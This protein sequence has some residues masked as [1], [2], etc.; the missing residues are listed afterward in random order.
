[1]A[2]PVSPSRGFVLL[3]LTMLFGLSAM[4]Q[5]NNSPQDLAD[6]FELP[7]GFHIYRAA[8]PELSGGSYALTFDGEGRLLVGDGNAVR[9]LIDKDGDGVFDSHEVIATG[10]GWR[11]PQGLLVYGDKLYAVGG[12]GIQ[13]FE[14]YRSGKELVHTGRI[15]NKLNT[16]GDHDAHTIFRGHDGYVYFMAGNGSG[17]EDRRHITDE[18]SPVM[19]EREASVF[20]ISPDGTKWECIGSGGRNPPNLGMNYL[21]ELFS[22]DSDM[23]W[24]V[25]LPW[26]RPVR[27]NHW[28]TG[29]DQGWQDVGAY[30]PYYIDCLP[31]ILD[32]GRGSPNWGV[33][34]EHNQFPEKYRDAYLVCDY[35]WKRESDDQ[36]A[37]T[38]RLVV[39]FLKREGAG[40]KASMETLARPKPSARDAEG[41]PINFA[42]VDAEVAP[43]GSLF[44]T[45]HNQGIWRIY[46]R[47][48]DILSAGGVGE[49]P[50][51]RSAPQVM[52]VPAEGKD[53]LDTLL[54]LPQPASE[55]SRLREVA[56]RGA[57]GKDAETLLQKTALNRKQPLQKRL[58]AIRL[59]APEFINLHDTFLQRLAM[60]ISPEIRGQAAWLMGIRHAVGRDSVEPSN[61]E[62]ARADSRPTN[63]SKGGGRNQE[64]FH[65]LVRL[66][67]DKDAFVRRR[68]AEALTR[69]HSPSAI[70]ALIERLGD[71]ERL[72]RYVAMTA[73]AHY[74]THDWFEA[75][76]AKS[77]PQIRMRALVVSLI[78]R[79]PPSDDEVRRVAKSF[80]AGAS[81]VTKSAAASESE[82]GQ[83]ARDFLGRSGVVNA[84]TSRPR[85]LSREDCLDLMR[86]LALFKKQI[87]ADTELKRQVVGHLL[88]GFPDSDR[89]IRFEQVRLLG[90]YRVSE[91]FSKLLTLLVADRDEVTQF[92]IAQGICKLES[93]W[94]AVE[95]ER[96]LHWMH[97]TQ[98]GW[99]AQFNGKGVEFPLFWST[100]LADFA[101]NHRDALLRDL[102][103]VNFASLLGG[104]AID[105][106]AESPNASE[107]L[108]SLYR[109]NESA[110]GRV[111]IVSA[112]KRKPGAAVGVFLREEFAKQTEPRLRGVILQSL[113]VQPGD[114]ANLPLFR[115]GLRHPDVDVVVACAGGIV[116][117]KPDLDENLANLL[118]SRMAERRSLFYAIDRTL[119]ALSNQTRPDH[120]PEPQPGERLEESTRSAAIEFWKDW[121]E[122]RFGKK[123]EATLAAGGRGRSDEELH[124]IILGV[125]LHVGDTT[126]GAKVYERLQCNSC[127]GGGV[128]PGQEGRLFGP[129][130]AGVT[131]RLSRPDLADAI[132]Y[133]S[134]QVVDRFK[135]QEIQLKEGEPLAGFIT[136]QTDD[137]VTLAARDQV[138]RIPRSRIRSIEPQATSLMPERAVNSLTDEEIRDLLA[139]LDHGIGAAGATAK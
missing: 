47:A 100:V 77:N 7:P 120:K 39:F 30:P 3:A 136:E 88:Q 90:E 130:L 135:A 64:A 127:H 132:V 80:L 16:G 17:I 128:T 45:D 61:Q 129:D 72:V 19:F 58:R 97:G 83:P 27:L 126:R 46:Y 53:A 20:R 26:W 96:L 81:S 86:T 71:S 24:H 75:A 105:L 138:H 95:E 91:A 139:F 25:G 49:T 85:S 28:A 52:L 82:R 4:A 133:P 57:L 1:M 21:G 111:K 113:A 69:F 115:E 65:V 131:R 89:D 54:S 112:L 18:S 78:R 119:V 22:F 13:V 43:D 134:K 51:A 56:L 116:R 137:T 31:G 42:L 62:W 55:W 11:G 93:G 48:A 124:R 121:Y 125:D 76:M 102:S 103:K 108:L 110:D 8:G 114:P 63:N 92:H 87:E 59:L 66:L 98:K 14:G 106:M 123:F 84:R 36:Y 32:V 50:P 6:R 29:G 122:R 37:T 35:R 67:E 73:L 68:A 107:T 38:G 41:K 104:V 101:H 99:F 44:M 117:Y 34:Y 74:P 118:V 70:G 5:T 109:S 23:E 94:T 60:D 33:F 79:E 12:D 9:R 15:G 40:W 10:L 2:N